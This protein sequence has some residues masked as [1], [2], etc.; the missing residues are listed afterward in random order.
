MTRHT[1]QHEPVDTPA[2][3]KKRREATGASTTPPRRSPKRAYIRAAYRKSGDEDIHDLL[4]SQPDQ[5]AYIRAA[6]REKAQRDPVLGILTTE[7]AEL[8]TENAE[9]WHMVDTLKAENAELKTMIGGL[10]SQ[11]ATLLTAMLQMQANM[12]SNGGSNGHRAAPSGEPHHDEPPARAQRPAPAVPPAPVVL[13]DRPCTP[14]QV[15]AAA[16][17][18]LN[19]FG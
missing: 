2:T 15:E 17:N 3:T 14:E 5:S 8:K 1:A 9:L 4:A 18:F 16:G 6:I 10:Q 7:F 11:L 13:E 12:S 19:M